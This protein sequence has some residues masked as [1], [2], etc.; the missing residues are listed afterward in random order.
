MQTHQPMLYLQMQQLEVTLV[1][2]KPASV[3]FRLHYTHILYP[4]AAMVVPRAQI[5]AENSVDFR[6]PW[7]HRWPARLDNFS[8]WPN[9]ADKN[10]YK[11]PKFQTLAWHPGP[12]T[13]EHHESRWFI[14]F[15]SVC[16]PVPWVHSW[17]HAAGFAVSHFRRQ[18][19]GISMMH[20]LADSSCTS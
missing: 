12:L 19:T 4:A 3:I 9:M 5:V 6:Q 10:T 16:T 15:T 11:W 8:Q 7:G 2:C 20:C 1:L 17:I 14:R 13:D 18:R